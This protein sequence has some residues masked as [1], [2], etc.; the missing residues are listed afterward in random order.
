MAIRQVIITF[1]IVLSLCACSNKK[2]ETIIQ[3]V[4][5]PVTV[6]VPILKEPEFTRPRKPIY[7]TSRLTETSTSKDIAEAYVNTILELKRYSRSL[8]ILLEPYF[9]K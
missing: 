9:K 7:Y 6:E 5:R 1:A 2:P 3:Y 4:D 8:E